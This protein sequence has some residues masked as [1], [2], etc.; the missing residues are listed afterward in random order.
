MAERRVALFDRLPAFH[1]TR[2][3]EQSP[4]GILEA[5][6]GLVEGEFNA[7]RDNIEALYHDLFIETCDPWVIPY[8][9]DLVGHSL[10]AGDPWTLRADTADAIALR[11]RKGTIGAVELLAFDLTGWAAHAIELVQNLAWTQYL[12][13][14]RP[15]AGGGPAFASVGRHVV[16]RGGTATLRDP[17]TLSLIDTPF[18]AFARLADVSPPAWGRVAYNL[19][20][21]AVFLWRLAA[22]TVPFTTPGD[23]KTVATGLAT[24]QAAQ[25]VRITIHPLAER[26][27]LFNRLQWDSDAQ[28]LVVTQLD[29][30]PGPIAPT[31]LTTREASSAP[32]EY[33]AVEVYDPAV[34]S[35]DT[36]E[37]GLRLFLPDTD[38]MPTDPWTFRGADLCAWEDGLADS[39]DEFEIAIDPV[40]GRL[41]IGVDTT[42][43][44]TAIEKGLRVTYT[45]GAVGPI[46]AH[47]ISRPPVPTTWDQQAVPAPIAVRQDPAF[48]TIE[49]ALQHLADDGP[50]LVVEIQDSGTYDLDASLVTGMIVEDGGPNLAMGRP[51]LLRAADGE[52]PVIRLAQSLRLRPAL[53]TAANPADQP[54]LD[55][56]NDLLRARF[57]GIHFAPGS[58]MAAD[59]PLVA[60]VAIRALE[61]LDATLEP[62]GE[63]RKLTTRAP[64]RVAMRLA[65]GYGFA[66]AADSAHFALHPDIIVDRSV[67]GALFAEAEDYTLDVTDSI[68]D[69]Q[70]DMAISGPGANPAQEFG[71]PTRVHGVT[72]IG[73]TRVDGMRGEGGIFVGR[74][75]VD[76]NQSGCIQWSYFSGDADR[77]PQNHACVH[78]PDARLRFTRDVFGEPG[79]GQLAHTTAFDVRE[80]GPDDDAMGATGFL[81]QAHRFRNLAIRLGESLPVGVRPL[82]VPVT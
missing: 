32:A 35:V 78:G 11:R 34:P 2:D 12:N 58:A 74:L 54:A 9:G 8:L 31:R 33:V 47:P 38:F 14:Q 81:S 44:A 41:V 23:R 66:N 50:L 73:R 19:P 60:R 61:I 22:Y 28:P 10:L 52:R 65:A 36:S 80:R 70:G 57:E 76:D 72:I 26:V 77:L 71:P 7:L 3:A 43:R 48:P 1:R 18:D 13:D 17:A 25:V 56:K 40:L 15:D 4:A 67:I 21:L 6:L 68:V 63:A 64:G 62:G 16:I 39:L 59:D 42:A 29:A 49:Q 30:V 75:E 45:Y 20:N 51:L 55:A 37:V 24:P 53:V 5:Y 46:G 79:Y 69:A 82:L 27:R